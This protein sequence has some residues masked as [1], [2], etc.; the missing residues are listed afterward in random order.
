M[1]NGKFMIIHFNIWI[2]K[3]DII[4]KNEYFPQ[5]H[6]SKNIIAIESGLSNYLTKS[7]LKSPI[8]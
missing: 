8:L 2:D 3:T 7:G 4:I 1:S 5:P 6:T